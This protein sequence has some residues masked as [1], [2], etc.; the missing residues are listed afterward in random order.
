M[1]RICLRGGL[2]LDPEARE[3]APGCLLLEGGRI[4]ARLE[5]GAPAPDGARVVDLGGA[6]LAPGLLDVHHHGTAV[7][8]PASE[9]RQRLRH[10]AR[11]LVRHG[12]TGFLATSVTLPAPELGA[13][14]T[15][16]AEA[17]ADPALET[18]LGLHLEGPWISPLAL[19]AHA[20]AAVRP[21]DAAELAGVLDRGAGLIRMVTFAPELPGAEGL[22]AELARRG[23]V[24]ALG[25]SMTQPD[26][27][28]RVI[29]SGARHVTHLY[30]AMT[31]LHH[32]APGLP[33]LALADSRLTCD[34]ICD[35]VHVD[36]RVVRFTARA[37]G[38]RLLLIS[39]RVAPGPG[40]Q[41]ASGGGS[42]GLRDDGEAWRLADGRLAG[43]R[44]TLER[45]AGNLSGFAGASPCEAVA[46]CTLR[47]ARLLGLEAERGTLRPG[48]RAD[49]VVLDAEGGVRETWLA[50]RRA[51]PA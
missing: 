3:P 10:D 7:F 34:L 48:S 15:Q 18:L 32:R 41:F 33:G 36:P 44:L 11:E 14:V 6:R 8:G 1:D 4:A 29:A 16:A 9:L 13:F 22:Q 40:E 39:D 21:V 28:E 25:H 5:A 42:G 30:N 37:L 45:A 2:L 49:L 46:A 27:A 51:Y 50:G 17:A 23:V 43:S 35:G 31:Q 20:R 47:P 19:G 38:E 26:D 24:G 12:V